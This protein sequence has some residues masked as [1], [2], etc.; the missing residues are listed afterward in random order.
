MN[1]T[2]MHRLQAQRIKRRSKWKLV[3]KQTLLFFT[4]A[5]IVSGVYLY[6]NQARDLSGNPQQPGDAS[7]ESTAP[8]EEP[9]INLSFVGDV[10]MAGNVEKTLLEKGY[11]YPYSYVRELLSEDDYSIANLETPVTTRGTPHADK[12]Y[13]YKSSPDSLPA[14]KE[15]GIDAVNL[16]N[17]HTM[18]QGVEGL[19]D[20]FSALDAN[21]IDYVGAGSDSRRAYAPVYAERNGIKLAVLGFSRVVPQVSWY[22][23]KDKP[24]V[25]ASYDPALAVQ[26]I[27][28]ADANADVVVVIAHWGEE[29]KDFPVDHQ[30]EL[31]R[32]YLDAGA[33]LI[34]GG[35]PHVVQGL[36]NIDGKWI[37]YSLG[38]F[39]F[40]RSTEPKTW[41]S[42]ILQASCT[43]S[44]DCDLKI[45]PFYTELARP[46]PM[47]ETEGAALLNRIQSI[48]VN[49]RILPDGTVEKTETES[50]GKELPHAP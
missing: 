20:T 6:A 24:G 21:R 39:V 12:A 50:S 18:D 3:A 49:A 26:A 29:R 2:R 11:D 22:A 45:L 15:A 13:V 41:D 25:A 43:K 37:A 23:G 33:D 31:A 14:M 38:N 28:E 34:V 17:N 7:N 36:E 9:R 46:V 8:P 16:A 1:Q 30:K 10:M 32:T 35:H 48:S 40:T 44:G 5:V 47:N 42:M 27:K 19:L 4:V